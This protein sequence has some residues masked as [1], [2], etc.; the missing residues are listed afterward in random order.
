LSSEIFV[1]SL[2]AV[3][4]FPFI[5]SAINCCRQYIRGYGTIALPADLLY[6]SVL[7]V[8]IRCLACMFLPWLLFTVT[9]HRGLVVNILEAVCSFP[10]ITSAINHRRYIR[11][12]NCIVSN[13]LQFRCINLPT[14]VYIVGIVV[15]VGIYLF[16]KV[17]VKKC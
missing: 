13:F 5:T 17:C 7:L 6:S 11:G 4:S 2:E 10:F 8:P 16:K 3:C 12:S 1:N 14:S 9:A 15:G